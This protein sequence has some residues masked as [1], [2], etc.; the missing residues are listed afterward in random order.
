M[1]PTVCGVF[2]H[3]SL[4]VP[5]DGVPLGLA[6]VKF[7]PRKTFKGTNV[8]RGKVSATRIPI[9]KKESVRWL[10]HASERQLGI[11]PAVI[12]SLHCPTSRSRRRAGER[13]STL[14]KQLVAADGICSAQ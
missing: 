3:S 13:L 4:V 5:P 8:L 10:A 6:A 12:A 11:R 14:S 2:L 7:W 1:S 9:E